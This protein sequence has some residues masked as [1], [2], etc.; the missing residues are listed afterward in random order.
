MRRFAHLIPQNRSTGHSPSFFRRLWNEEN[1]SSLVEVSIIL[2]F[3]AP[4]MLLG[5]SEMAGM[6]YASIEGSDAA[7][8]G[9]AYAAEQYYKSS[10]TALPTTAQVTAAVKNDAPELVNMIKPGTTFTVT[11]ATGCNGGAAT[12]GNTIPTC[13]AGV[14]PYVQVTTQATVAPLAGFLPGTLQVNNRAIMNL[15]N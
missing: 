4:A 7:H 3:L 6:I 15:V 11:M 5:T 8:A 12:N 2:A 1:A 13:S 9:A 10:D 14:L